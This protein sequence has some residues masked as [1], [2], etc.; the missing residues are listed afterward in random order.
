[1]SGGTPRGSLAH[2]KGS[3]MGW[4]IH[5]FVERDALELFVDVCRQN[6]VKMRDAMTNIPRAKIDPQCAIDILP[7]GMVVHLV[8]EDANVTHKL[9]NIGKSLKSKFTG[10]LHP[11]L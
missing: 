1:M 2:Q 10:H 5:T 11:F 9:K 4:S 6:Q 8:T 7:P 3:E